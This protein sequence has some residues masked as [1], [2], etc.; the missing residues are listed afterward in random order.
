MA[1]KKIKYHSQP[2]FEIP[3]ASMLT[4][5]LMGEG[6]KWARFLVSLRS[7]DVAVMILGD[8]GIYTLLSCFRRV[9]SSLQISIHFENLCLLL[10]GYNAAIQALYCLH[11]T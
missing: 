10:S 11:R 9:V 1:N 8:T 6:E 2:I 5:G 4:L 3:A 7:S